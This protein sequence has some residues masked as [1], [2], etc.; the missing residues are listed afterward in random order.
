MTHSSWGPGWPNCDSNS[1]VPLNVD[2]IQFPGGCRVEIHELLTLLVRETRDNG[3]QFGTPND[4]SYG[5]W[6]FNCRCISGTSTPSNHSWGL[7]VDINAPSNPQR[8][9]LTTDM[10][11]WMPYLWNDYGFRWGGDYSGTP[12]AMH[13]EFMGS[14]QDCEY[15]T[16]LARNTGLGSNNVEPEPIIDW[17]FLEEEGDNM[18][19]LI[20]FPN[21]SAFVLVGSYVAYGIQSWDDV[22]ALCAGLKIEITAVSENMANRMLMG[23]TI[24]A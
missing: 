15:Y 20:M 14:V 18:F 1:I 3:Y 23:R 13:Y 21:G 16:Q 11:D 9:P 8:H 5:C 19:Q 22:L 4:P 12:D 17:R 2:G 7:A 24:Y 6:G 10:P